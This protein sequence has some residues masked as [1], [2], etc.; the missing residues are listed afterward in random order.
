MGKKI[1]S[2]DE[3][4]I[5]IR[6]SELVLVEAISDFRKMCKKHPIHSFE[7]ELDDPEQNRNAY[8]KLVSEFIDASN[9]AIEYLEAAFD[10]FVT[11]QK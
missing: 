5:K 11:S 1:E 4:D 9:A 6:G 8:I 2:Q 7:C 3:K 10:H